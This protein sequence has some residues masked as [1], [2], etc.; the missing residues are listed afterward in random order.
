MMKSIVFNTILT[1]VAT[2][3]CNLIVIELNDSLSL[4]ICVAFIDLIVIVGITFVYCFLAEWI[5]TDLLQ[6]G[7][8]LYNS[9]WYQ[10]LSTN[11][12]KL[13]I[14]PFIRA[15]RELRLTGLGF[16]DCSLAVFAW[17]FILFN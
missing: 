1:C 17:V 5:T 16:F 7:D 2:I 3:A 12:Q 10:V 15:G 4:E 9:P 6:I 8:I 14:L 13:L 11:K